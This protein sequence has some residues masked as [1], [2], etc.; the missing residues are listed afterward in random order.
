MAWQTP[1]TN[2]GQ[3]GQTVPGATD[4]NRIEGNT[5]YLKD[6]ID[7]HLA[8]YEYQT[9]TIVGTQIQLEKQSDTA[10]LKFKLATDLSGG[11]ITIST[12]EGD[13]DKPL[14]DIEGV[15]VTELDKGFVEVVENAVNFTYAPKGASLKEANEIITLTSSI[16]Y[17]GTIRYIT[18]DNNYLYVGGLT[19]QKVYKLNKSDLSKVAESLT[20]GGTI[21]S[22]TS[23][24]NYLYVGGDTQKVYKL[25]KSDLSKVAE[26]LTYGGTIWSITSDDNY[27]YVGGDTQKVYKLNKSDL[28]KVSESLTYG[29]TI[30]SIT[31]DDNYLYVGGVTTNKVYKLNKVT[32]LYKNLKLIPIGSV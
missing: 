6:E 12:D 17:G 30:L 5:Q 13:T 25:N 1:K 31:S 14:V 8:D 2:W 18:S 7:S 16:D 10:I 4:F 15:A 19:T 21:Y 22:I 26:S 27:L 32:Y 3:A 11:A 24:D 29:G 23:D 28:S 9:P 20:Y